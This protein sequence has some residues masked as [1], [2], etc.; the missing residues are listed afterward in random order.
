MGF[1]IINNQQGVSI[2][3]YSPYSYQTPTNVDLA[4]D[5]YSINWA[6]YIIDQREKLSL[7]LGEVKTLAASIKSN[8][9]SIRTIDT[10]SIQQLIHSH[11][12]VLLL[13]IKVVQRKKTNELGGFCGSKNDRRKKINYFFRYIRIYF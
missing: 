12:M 7:Q 11:D 13:K 4:T 2:F 5:Q 1:G 3:L 9:D 6:D 8:E 10:S